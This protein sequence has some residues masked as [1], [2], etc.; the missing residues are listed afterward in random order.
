MVGEDDPRHALRGCGSK[1][2]KT[3]A[4]HEGLV[5]EGHLGDLQVGDLHALKDDADAEPEQDGPALQSMLSHLA[6]Q[7]PEAQQ[8]AGK[9]RQKGPQYSPF[10]QVRGCRTEDVAHQNVVST[11]L[12]GEVLVK[13]KDQHDQHLDLDQHDG[14]QGT[15]NQ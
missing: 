15:E 1:T 13:E 8:A 4:L 3:H 10:A 14:V 5:P 9:T 12:R 11:A 2:R 6:E 7:S